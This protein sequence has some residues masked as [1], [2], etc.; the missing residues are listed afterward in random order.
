MRR[1]RDDPELVR[2][3]GSAAERPGRQREPDRVDAGKGRSHRD[4]AYR[5]LAGE[6]RP[7]RVRG[8][9]V[10]AELCRS[11]QEG[12]EEGQGPALEARVLCEDDR[13]VWGRWL[14]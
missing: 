10:P 2:L 5:R 13:T 3:A 4:P 6:R 9:R 1:R 7:L 12:A 14:P 11:P 8:P